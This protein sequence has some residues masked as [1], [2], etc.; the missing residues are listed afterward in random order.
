MKF[1][2]PIILILTL[3]FFSRAKAQIAL[4]YYPLS[5]VFAVGTD[6]EKLLSADL[7]LETNS[8][9]GLMNSEVQ[10]MWNWRRGNWLNYY[11][12][13]GIN[14]KPFYAAS[15]LSFLNGYVIS[16]GIRLKPWQK[17]PQFQVLFELSPFFYQSWEGASLRSSLGVA[18]NF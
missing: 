4:S 13:L 17:Q 18:Y 6:N 16:T 3:G 7:R 9:I 11:S 5:S 2:A 1:F 8:F 14:F 10:L 12:G 15:D